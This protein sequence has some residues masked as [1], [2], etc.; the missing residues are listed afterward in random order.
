MLQPQD[1]ESLV[2]LRHELHTHPEVSGNE[3]ET[4]SRIKSWLKQVLPE[5][6]L[7]E[8][9][10]GLLAISQGSIEGP[11]TLVRAELDALP[12]EEVNEM[13]YISKAKCIS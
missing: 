2:A 4:R 10:K 11:V 6:E 7:V 3:S 12:I 13:S 1:L 8:A 9:G 5:V